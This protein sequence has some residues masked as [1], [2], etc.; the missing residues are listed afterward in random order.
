MREGCVVVVVL[1]GLIV[2]EEM[3]VC[4]GDDAWSDGGVGDG[5]VVNGVVLGES[6]IRSIKIT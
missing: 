2:V 1:C 5:G 6:K 4:G 3:G